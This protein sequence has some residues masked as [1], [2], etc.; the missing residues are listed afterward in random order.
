MVSLVQRF[1]GA[2]LADL[3]R[4]A[5]IRAQP[6][7]QDPHLMI[8]AGT[9]HAQ[10]IADDLIRNALIMDVHDAAELLG[11]PGLATRIDLFLQPG[12]NT[13]EVSERIESYLAKRTQMIRLAMAAGLAVSPQL[14]ASAGSLAFLVGSPRQPAQVRTPEAN[15]QR[16]QDVMAGLQIRVSLCGFIAM[17]VGLFLVY[18]ALAF[19]VTDRGPW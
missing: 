1:V 8:K 12:V 5:P 6:A 15:N 4:N 17:V 3:I 10:G 9:V 7:N 11:Q 19:T 16:I 2:E 13:P 18:I 14:P